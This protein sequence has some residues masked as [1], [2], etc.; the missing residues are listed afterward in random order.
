MLKDNAESSPFELLRDVFSKNFQSSMPF[1]WFLMFISFHQSG[2]T[3]CIKFPLY[4]MRRLYVKM[5]PGNQFH[6]YGFLAY[7]IIA[8]GLRY[9]L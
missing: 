1:V 9:R 7:R 6:E 5:V 3:G 2:I 8:F 4:G